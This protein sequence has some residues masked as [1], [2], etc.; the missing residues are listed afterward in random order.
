M[1]IQR[2][3]WFNRDSN[4]TN[5]IQREV[6]ATW[7]RNSIYLVTSPSVKSASTIRLLR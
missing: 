5:V 6:T 3:H 4:V 7:N 2:L 1:Y